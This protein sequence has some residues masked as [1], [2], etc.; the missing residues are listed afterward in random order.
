MAL[1]GPQF[2]DTVIPA[3]A[4]IQ[5]FPAGMTPD[6]GFRRGDVFCENIRSGIELK[7]LILSILVIPVK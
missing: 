1:Q 4:G 6:P 5:E 3:Q 7:D 2:M